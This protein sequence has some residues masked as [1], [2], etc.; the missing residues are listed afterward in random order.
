MPDGFSD[1]PPFGPFDEL[2]GP[3]YVRRTE[4]GF[5]IGLLADERHRN[6]GDMVHGGMIAM[7]A[8]SVHM[9]RQVLAREPPLALVTTQLS[10][11]LI[12]KARPC[13]WIEARVDVIR[14]GRRAVFSNCFIWAGGKRVAQATAQFQ[15]V[16]QRN[17]PD[18]VHGRA[19]REASSVRLCP[20]EFDGEQAHD[21]YWVV[22]GRRHGKAGSK[23]T[24]AI[25]RPDRTER[26][27]PGARAS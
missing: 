26:V 5:A 9:G 20:I 19:E 8:D 27:A 25:S 18:T 11:S 14:A 2:V 6:R 13:E 23:C 10:L 21:S 24:A 15:V 3:M 16:D 1:T 17:D 7:L 4:E 22:A 12:G